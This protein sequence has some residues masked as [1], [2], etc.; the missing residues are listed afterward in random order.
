M[1]GLCGASESAFECAVGWAFGDDG[2]SYTLTATAVDTAG[3]KVNSAPV[4]ITVTAASS[5]PI[6]DR[7]SRST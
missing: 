5:V 1:S 2:Q 3:T 7:G 6:A 4:V